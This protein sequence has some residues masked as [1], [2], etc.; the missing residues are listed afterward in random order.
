MHLRAWSLSLSPSLPLS[1]P[2]LCVSSLVKSHSTAITIAIWWVLKLSSMVDKEPKGD[3]EVAF[4]GH[5]TGMQ[6]LR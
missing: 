6:L 2:P 1:P 4:E 5:L 3:Y